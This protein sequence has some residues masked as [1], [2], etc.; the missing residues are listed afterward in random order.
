MNEK[1]GSGNYKT[2]YFYFLFQFSYSS[3]INIVLL[4][5]DVQYS[6]LTTPYIT[7]CSSR[8]VYS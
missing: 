5:S 3:M 8:Q 4:V 2:K 7:Q 6:D 1:R